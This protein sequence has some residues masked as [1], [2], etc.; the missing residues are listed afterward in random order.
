MFPCESATLDLAD[1]KWLLKQ[2]LHAVELPAGKAFPFR[3]QELWLYVQL[4][5]GLGDFNLSIQFADRESGVVLGSSDVIQRTFDASNRTQ[6]VEEV[7]RLRGLV[8]P[9][10]GV[11]EFRL[12]GN[13]QPLPGG[14]AVLRVS[15]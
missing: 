13:H 10:A 9:R 12:I 14:V 11:Y 2:P 1:E 5:Y 7:F 15:G 3:V 8:I 4:M 6:A